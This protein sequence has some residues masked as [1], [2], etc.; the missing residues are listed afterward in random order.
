M[1]L[2]TVLVF[3]NY[4][5]TQH[6]CQNSKPIQIWNSTFIYIYLKLTIKQL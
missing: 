5:F 6:E 2:K 1:A 4:K 3:K